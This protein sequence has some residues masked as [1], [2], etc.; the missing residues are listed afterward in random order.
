MKSYRAE[1]IV[2]GASYRSVPYATRD[3]AASALPRLLSTRFW[4]E[5]LARRETLASWRVGIV[6]E[7]GPACERE[8]GDL[9]LAHFAEGLRRRL[10]DQVVADHFTPQP[11]SVRERTS[12]WPPYSPEEAHLEIFYLGGRWFVTWKRLELA[13]GNE[14][15]R[16]ELMRIYSTERG[17]TYYEV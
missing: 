4:Q 12:P 5:R 1:V 11:A 14:E 9:D 6:E 3:R 8:L 15:E 17:V 16:T 7:E 10:Y 2:S 13:E